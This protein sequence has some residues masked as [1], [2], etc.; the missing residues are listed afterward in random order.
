MAQNVTAMV[1]YSRARNNPYYR[2]ALEDSPQYVD[3]ETMRT[4]L[5]EAQQQLPGAPAVPALE[6]AD[7][8]AAWLDTVAETDAA[9]HAREI[10]FNALRDRLIWCDKV[11]EGVVTVETDRILTS[12]HDALVEVMDQ[13]AA[14]V[15][16]LNGARTPQQV[17][18]A[19]VSDAWKELRPLR[20]EYDQVRTAQEWAMAGEDQHV[21]SRSHYLLGDPLATDIAIANLDTV[22]PGWRDK[23]NR[24]INL[25]DAPQQDPRPWPQDP[26]EQLVWLCTSDAE[27]WVPT[28]SELNQLNRQRIARLNPPTGKTEATHPKPKQTIGRLTPQRAIHI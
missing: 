8:I 19:G 4:K 27:P 16:R 21:G 28:L 14:V 3:A 11:V 12:L 1:V 9:E 5:L 17:I 26:V 15:D 6:T 10:K 7:D 25:S 22:F 18:D 24:A 20:T 13:V 2:A 23:D